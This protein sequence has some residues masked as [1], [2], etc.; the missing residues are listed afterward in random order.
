MIFFPSTN[1]RYKRHCWKMVKT[2]YGF[3]MENME[4][5]VET[6]G[7]PPEFPS[8]P[9]SYGL[10]L[11]SHRSAGNL[12]MNWPWALPLEFTTSRLDDWFKSYRKII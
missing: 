9:A 1:S 8:W 6:H 5:N 2:K 10:N 3:A 12:A 11:C 7:F 4:K